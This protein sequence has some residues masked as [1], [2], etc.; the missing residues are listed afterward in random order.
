MPTREEIRRST[1][2]EGIAE[3]ILKS[4]GK[5]EKTIDTAYDITQYL[6]DN[7]VVLKVDRECR[8]CGR[9]GAIKWNPFNCV[10]QCHHCGEQYSIDEIMA[11]YVATESLIGGARLGEAQIEE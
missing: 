9:S 4:W 8:S 10:I 1:I 11:G 2:R 3:I 7:D 6:H 5:S